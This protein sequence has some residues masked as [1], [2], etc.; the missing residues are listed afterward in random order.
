MGLWTHARR[1]VGLDHVANVGNEDAGDAGR[2]ARSAGSPAVRLSY[3]TPG[4]LVPTAAAAIAGAAA[5]AI[6]FFTT[7]R[8]RGRRIAASASFVGPAHG[9]ISDAS[10]FFQVI[11]AKEISDAADWNMTGWRAA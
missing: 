1:G 10:C 4:T 2:V 5:A 11:F 6:P 9:R 8:R 3:S 7:S